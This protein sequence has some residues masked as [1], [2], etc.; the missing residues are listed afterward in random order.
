LLL[1]I[2]I[3]ECLTRAKQQTIYCIGATALFVSCDDS[4]RSFKVIYQ[5]TEYWSFRERNRSKW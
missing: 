3:I 1:F 5:I 2:I 4:T